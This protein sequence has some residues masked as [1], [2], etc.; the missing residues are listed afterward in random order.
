MTYKSKHLPELFWV[1]RL[2]YFHTESFDM[3]LKSAHC[4]HGSITHD[5]YYKYFNYLLYFNNT[6]SSLRETYTETEKR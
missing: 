2:D 1:E 5:M 3:A 4:Y 6:V